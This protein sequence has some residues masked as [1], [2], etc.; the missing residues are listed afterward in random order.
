MK[1]SLYS[2]LFI[3]HLPSESRLLNWHLHLYVHVYPAIVVMA[4]RQSVI[5]DKYLIVLV[6]MCLC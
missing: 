5:L 1:G 4:Q 3:V 2:S 6:Q